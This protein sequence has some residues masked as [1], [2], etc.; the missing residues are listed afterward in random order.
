MQNCKRNKLTG[1]VL[2]LTE[3]YRVS[4]L[5]IVAVVAA[6]FLSTS[7]SGASPISTVE[8]AAADSTLHW[9]EEIEVNAERP[10]EFSDAEGRR[11]L[12]SEG[13]RTGA[14]I[15]GESDYINA[16]KVLPGI[17]TVGDYGSGISVNG[18]APYQSLFS[19][20]GI[21]VL[22]P[23]RFGGI[24]STFNSPYFDNAIFERSIHGSSFPNRIGGGLDLS[25]PGRLSHPHIELN[26]GLISSSISATVPLGA[27]VDVMLA[28]R[29]SYIDQIYGRWLHGKT[30]Y[31][32]Y[33]YGD[34]NAGLNFRPTSRDAIGLQFVYSNDR[35][36]IVD[37]NFGMLTHIPWQNV[38]GGVNWRHSGATPFSLKLFHTSFSNSIH[39]QM[40]EFTTF[41]PASISSTGAEAIVELPC[42]PDGRLNV[43]AGGEILYHFARPMTLDYAEG[44]VNASNHNS[45][46]QHSFETRPFAE[47]D[48]KICRGLRLRGGVSIT[49]YHNTTSSVAPFSEFDVDPRIT[50]SYTPCAY[51]NDKGKFG[52]FRLHL[53]SYR[54]NLHQ[55]GISE[56]GLASNFWLLSR[57]GIPATLGR[58]LA[59]DWTK[60]LFS[61]MLDLKIEGFC[62]LIRNQP[63]YTGQILD[64]MDAD[65]NPFNHIFLSRGFNAG[66]SVTLRKDY[67][68]LTGSAGYSFSTSRRKGGPEEGWW[69]SITDAGHQLN[70]SLGYRLGSHWNLGASFRL[71]SGRPW[72]P[73][74]AFYL[75]GGN[76][77][78]VYG[79]I[80]SSR[81]PMY[82]RLDLSATYSFTTGRKFRLRHLLNFSLLNAYGHKNVEFRYL[83]FNS[84]NYQ[85]EIKDEYS[86]YRFLPSLSYTI[87]WN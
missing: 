9:L 2:L 26:L 52:S 8:P 35:L 57:N 37:V 77:V 10:K 61:G 71:A 76:I 31:Y 32:R 50:L 5:T 30:T 4:F 60:S 68:S 82:Q 63:E 38:A 55:T 39:L 11:V 24:F 33:R 21:P 34:L 17:T 40:P 74:N 75:L 7:A 64:L 23:Y 41:L 67:G 48:W 25:V 49:Y 84:K 18:A 51:E 3:R 58:S 44:I 14:R 70:V 87:I 54:Q 56:I 19:I 6:I 73:I 1:A 81:L 79:K 45:I 43:N 22:F 12:S 69:N 47:V 80:N 78:S 85:V 15:M 66:G 59:A 20:E 29:V 16:V 62:S 83:S 65:Y 13:I 27:K 28:G 72:T 36:K 86:M 42:R 46:S 53:G